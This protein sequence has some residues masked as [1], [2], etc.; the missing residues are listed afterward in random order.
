MEEEISLKDIILALWKGRYFIIGI[1]VG[2]MLIAFAASFIITTPLYEA[3]ATI[4]TAEDYIAGGELTRR[5]DNRNLHEEWHAEIFEAASAGEP[6]RVGI[7]TGDVSFEQDDEM[8]TILA[9]S[10]EK[11]AAQQMAT[12]LGLE[13]L[14]W[15]AD[16]QVE[17]L[18]EREENLALEAD[19]M[20]YR[21][22][23]Y[24]PNLER[25]YREL[26]DEKE[27]LEE[28]LAMVEQQIEDRYGDLGNEERLRAM[29]VDSTY[30]ALQERQGELLNE[31]TDVEITM[32]KIDRGRYSEELKMQDP[33]YE[34]MLE[35]ER[36]LKQQKSSVA[37]SIGRTEQYLERITAED[38][39]YGETVSGSP[40]NVRWPLNTA[41]AA[42]LGLMLSVFVVFMRPLVT[43][44]REEIKK[45]N[46]EE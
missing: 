33:Y 9:K 1:T 45:T 23:N 30:I 5:V 14:D 20:D 7:G 40:V 32:Q 16:Y 12:R 15:A 18:K 22:D 21:L 35:E 8:L 26:V 29:E 34:F 28:S 2:A 44:L 27:S 11:E 39:I 25:Y 3:R 6:A 36:D 37:Y 38:H 24:T 17:L 46:D 4:D 13:L 19:L 10:T 31:L 42:V 43:D 41:V